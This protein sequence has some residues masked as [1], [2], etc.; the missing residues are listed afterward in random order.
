MTSA[1]FAEASNQLMSRGGTPT[2]ASKFDQRLSFTMYVPRTLDLTDPAPL[3]VLQHG[4]ARTALRYRDSMRPFADEH[5]AI[6]LAPTFPAGLVDPYDLHNYKFI[7]YEGI[8][9]DLALLSMIDEV[10]E[11]YN[12]QKNKIYLHGYSGGG[13]F[14]HRFLY[15]HPERLAAVSIG[16]PGR[17]TELD[18]TK[19]WW[20]GTQGMKEKFGIEPDIDAIRQVPVHMVVGG[21]DTSTNEINNPG[22]S[23]W[24]DGAELTGNTRIERL[25]TLQRNYEGHGIST[26]LD[27]VPGVAHDGTAVLPVVG[28][29]FAN[30]MA[31]RTRG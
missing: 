27:I 6:I 11:R 9:F 25:Q 8:R 19:K 31:T 4:T 12:I 3:I 23:N 20:L 18:D 13:Q 29:F 2:F 14:V 22:E 16:A 10:A 1:H 15:L 28:E 26:K 5:G 30:V 7:E 24:M 17:I 21:E